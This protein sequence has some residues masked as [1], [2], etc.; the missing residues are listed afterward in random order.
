MTVLRNII[1]FQA[2]WFACVLGAAHGHEL[3]GIAIA[4]VIVAWHF[5]SATRPR[6]EIM[7]V[8]IAAA[9]GIAWESLLVALGWIEY[10]ARSLAIGLA[11]AWMVALWALFA[12]TL[13]V[14]LSWLKP[15]LAL[16]AALGA[17]SGPAAYY[18]GDR[19]GALVLAYP[20]HALAALAIGWGM[21][22][23]VLLVA[24]RRLNGFESAA[25]NSKPA[26]VAHARP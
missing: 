21:L 13:N 22:T 4:A 23:P 14:S 6:A 20:V 9:V 5:A 25:I 16:A 18:G 11:P 8:A 26:G 1:A 3:W 19:L 24:A 10:P 2:G 17:I 15:R 7:L 12:T